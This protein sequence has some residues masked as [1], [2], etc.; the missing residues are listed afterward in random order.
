MKIALVGC[1]Y[2]ADLYVQTLVLHPELNLRGVYD[3]NHTR[4]KQFEQH[5]QISSYNSFQQLLDSDAELILNLTNPSSHYEVTLACLEAGKHVYSEKPLAMD[6]GEAKRLVDLAKSKNLLIA[7]APCSFLGQSAQTLWKAVR[8]RVLGDIY[9]VYA[10]MDDGLVHRMPYQKWRSASGAPWPAI[11]EFE[12][13]CT[14]EH[15]GYVLS[16]LCG[17]FGPAKNVTA[18]GS[19]SIKDKGIDQ[20]LTRMSPDLTV[21][22][23]AFECGLVAR[24]TCSIVGEH[25]HRIRLFCEDGILGTDDSWDYRS[26]VWVRRYI[27]IRRKLMLSPFRKRLPLK[28]RSNKLVKYGGSSMMDFCRGPAEMAQSLAEQRPCRLSADF[29]LHINEVSLAISNATSSG[30]RHELVTRFDPMEP[31]PWAR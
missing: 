18:F 29:S 2:V 10:E 6:F 23:I 17:M 11:D 26:P 16:W 9:A 12:V 31:M 20:P 14:L 27:A 3:R 15:A 22:C 30:I 5:Y 21:A 19:V 7:S 25:D 24:L 4:L 1:G 8:E 28:G 13:G